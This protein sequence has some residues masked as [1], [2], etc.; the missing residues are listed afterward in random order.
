MHDSY[1]DWG[2]ARH[3]PTDPRSHAAMQASL[4]RRDADGPRPDDN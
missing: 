2:P 4:D 3:D 1:P